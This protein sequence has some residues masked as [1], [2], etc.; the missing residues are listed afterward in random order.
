MKQVDR[1]YLLLAILFQSFLLVVKAFRWYILNEEGFNFRK[2]VR[3]SG[4]FFEGYAIGVVTPGRFGELMKA[5]HG[6][7]RTGILGAGMRVIAERGL[8]LSIFIIIGGISISQALLPGVSAWWGWLI[9]IAGLFGMLLA[10]MILV[11]PAVVGVAEKLMKMIRLLAK[12]KSLDFIHR[13]WSNTALF[14]VLSVVGNLSYFTCCYFLAI[15]VG[16]DLSVV[17]VSGGVAAAGVMNTIPVTIMGL[18]TRELTFL[19]VFRSFPLAQVMAFSGL[20]F[21]IAQ[22]G[23][24]LVSL[25]LGQAL[26]WKFQPSANEPKTKSND[27]S[28]E[29]TL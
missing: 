4:E 16:M 11:S 28:P 22:V 18:G 17:E 9:L 6:G 8:D 21:L 19:F 25:L 1:T 3:R 23:A 2:L 13:P 29:T 10:V 7:T 14:F 5:G 26:L 15:G 12:E 24:G 27:N 20:V